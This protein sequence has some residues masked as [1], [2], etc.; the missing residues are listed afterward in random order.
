MIEIKGPM[1]P[2][3]PVM[4]KARSLVLAT[5]SP[6]ALDAFDTAVR[7]GTLL[8]LHDKYLVPQ[9]G[10]TSIDPHLK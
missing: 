10:V 8:A 3:H 4:V 6:R 5:G 2:M 1:D 7:T 9:A